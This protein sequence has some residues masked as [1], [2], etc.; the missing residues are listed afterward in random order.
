MILLAFRHGNTFAPGAPVVRAGRQPGLALVAAGRAQAEAAGL[1]LR[2]A[3]VAAD[4]PICTSPRL[5]AV[6]FAECLQGVLQG[7]R[8]FPR[9]DERLDEIDYGPWTGLTRE[10]I[11]QRWGE[12]TVAAWDQ[13]GV[14]PQSVGWRPTE[15]AFAAQ[16]AA[17]VVDVGAQGPRGL[18][19]GS[20][21]R[22]PVQVAGTHGGTLRYLVRACTRGA[23]SPLGVPPK[24]PCGGV[25]IVRWQGGAPELVACAPTLQAPVLRQLLGDQA[26]AGSGATL[27]AATALG[28]AAGR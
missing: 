17:F 8:S 16:V 3:G 1:A 27:A 10:A 22:P 28:V 25:V 24:I 11:V 2:E 14:W 5:R 20:G 4:V 13:C 21:G 19:A 6:Q 9:T 26:R 15:A 23:Q 12:P 7:E 18:G